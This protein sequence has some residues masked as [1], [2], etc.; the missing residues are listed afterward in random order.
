MRVEADLATGRHAELAAELRALVA[1]HPWRERLHAH[2]MLA[3]YRTG[4]QAE[5]LEA[6]AAARA[7]LVE[8]LGIEPGPELRDLQTAILAH[9]P[10]LAP[11]GVTRVPALPAA[12]TALF[13]R[14]DDLDRLSEQLRQRLAWSPS[15]AR[16]A[17]ARPASRWPRPTNS[18]RLRRRG[19]LRP[20]GRRSRTLA[21]WRARSSAR[22]PC[23]RRAAL[24]TLPRRPRAAAR[25]RQLR[26]ARGGGSAGGRAARRRP[27]PDRAG[28]EPRGDPARRRA[29][30][31]ARPAGRA[32]TPPRCSPI[33]YGRASPTSSPTTRCGRSAS[34][35]TACRS[36]SSSPRRASGC[37]RPPSSPRGSI[38][39]C[40]CSLAARAMRRSASR[41]CGRR[42]TGATSCSTRPNAR[43]SRGSP[44]SRAEPRV[45][46]AEEVTGASLDTLQSLVAKQLLRRRGD[47][48]VML[49]LVREY[50]LERLAPDDP[51]HARLAAWCARSP[52]AE[53]APA[54]DDADARAGAGRRAAERVRRDALGARHGR[55]RR[56]RRHRDRLGPVLAGHR[57]PRRRARVGGHRARARASTR[58][59]ARAC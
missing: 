14:A 8:Q 19:P 11:P 1:E 4:R 56:G 50:A 46:A 36:P 5:A 41:R 57:P 7:A 13:G 51:A 17:S 31:P 22:S 30:V 35:S 27:A 10:R 48:L 12:P 45:P 32:R 59:V 33:A 15:W 37:C 44:C 52:T 43:R 29:R 49:A 42:S 53:A 28:D 6:Y 9:D 2:L 20:A 47:R 25:A 55:G 16:A 34:G 40:R 3:L 26:A 38:T 39:R 21:S 18:S 54:L 58:T 23:P 24:R